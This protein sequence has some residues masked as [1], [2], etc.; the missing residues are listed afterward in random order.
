MQSSGRLFAILLIL[1][2]CSLL[3]AHD[4]TAKYLA[5]H[6]YHPLQI[7]WAR[8][9]GHFLVALVLLLRRRLVPWNSTRLK[10]QMGRTVMLVAAS[11]CMVV[12]LQ[13]VP[14]AD[15]ATI[16]MTNPLF[17]TVL[18]IPLLGERVGWRRMVALVIGFSGTILVL[19]PGF[20]SFEPYI[21]FTLV[22]AILTAFYLISTRIVAG[23]DPYEISFLWA[24]L[25]G[26]LGLTPLIPFVWTPPASLLDGVLL[27]SLSVWAGIGHFLIIVAHRHAPAPVLAPFSYCQLLVTIL[28]G[29]LFFGR[30]PDLFTLLGAALLVGS[31]LYVWQREWRR[32]RSK[33]IVVTRMPDGSGAAGA[34]RP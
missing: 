10:L 28:L 1:V 4:T 20:A 8:Y 21:L 17:V 18:A 19:R 33:P 5:T 2:A 26:A 16:I 27:A 6:G 24:S 12:S 22:A 23:S 7:V 30:G 25:G 15:A 14:L 11:Y 3:A 13:V 9:L 32:A 34:G 29:I 31:G